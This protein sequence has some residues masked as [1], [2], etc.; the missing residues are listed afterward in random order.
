MIESNSGK[1]K[2][3]VSDML[4]D[5]MLGPNA[6]DWADRQRKQALQREQ[7]RKAWPWLIWLLLVFCVDM[8]VV[9]ADAPLWLRWLMSLMIMPPLVMIGVLR[10][11]LIARMDEMQRNIEYRAMAIIFVSTLS[12]LLAGAVLHDMHVPVHIP[13]LLGFWLF[14]GGY[15]AVGKYL[16]YR[17]R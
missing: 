1:G 5:W 14:F 6:D 15:L 9:P 7:M 17:Y 3:G 10:M 2:T 11:R 4:V 12:V 8:L 13:A 16:R